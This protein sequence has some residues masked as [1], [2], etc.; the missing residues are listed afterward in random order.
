MRGSAR[1]AFR[2]QKLLAAARSVAPGLTGLRAAWLHFVDGDVPSAPSDARAVLDRLLDYEVGPAAPLPR[3]DAVVVPRP[4]TISPWSTKATDIARSCGVPLRRIER[5]VGWV[6]EG[7]WTAEER[8]AVLPLLHDR[9]TEAV[10]ATPEA[11]SVLFAREA[12]RPFATIPL[13]DGGRQALVDADR[14]LG[15]ALATDEIDYLVNAFGELGRDPT[16]VELMMFAQ[17]NSEHCR[18]KIFNASW[19]VDGEPLDR[20]LFKMI[21]HT[22]QVSPGKVLSAYSD[23]AAVVE[24]YAVNRFFPD[25]DGV[26]RAHTER[27]HLLMKV[28]THNHP[29]G[30][31][32]HPGAATGAGGEIRDEGTTGRGATT[33]TGR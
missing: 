2:L 31:S 7:E 10:L 17:A 16:D 20:S 13:R 18:H 9:M 6:L 26:Y 27:A 15:L 19:T 24:G 32:P 1:S 4:G 23:N 28:E 21:R 22:H 12:P 29:T 3:V 30:I 33:D 5:G 25:P 8:L 14:R 11:A